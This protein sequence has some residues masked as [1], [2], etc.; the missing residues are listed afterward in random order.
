MPCGRCGAKTE[1]NARFCSGCGAPLTGGHP[2]EE[3]KRVS[4]IFVDQVGSTARA[5][6]ADP[7][8]V[9]DRNRLFYEEVR[10]RIEDH[11]GLLEKYAGDAVMAVF[12]A[13]L[14]R[15]ND[16]ESAVRAG[17]SVLEG[18][19]E[20]N[21][22]HQN[23]QLEVRIGICTGEAIVEIDPPPE[24]ALATG[25][26]VNTAARLESAAP[27]GAVIVGPETYRLTKH[28]FGYR[29]L[30]PIEA[31]GKKEP[32]PAWIVEAEA[33][34][35]PA[36]DELSASFVGRDRELLLLRTVWSQALEECQ[37]HLIT[38]IGP[39]GIGKSRLA[40][41]F[42][43]EA[44]RASGRILL[45]RCSAYEQQ[46]PYHAVAQTVRQAS[47]VFENDP[48]ETARAKVAT[49]VATMFPPDEAA[50]MTRFLSLV[51]GLGLDERAR[52][53]VELQ[54]AVRRFFERLSD[55]FP[56]LIVFEDL[57]WADDAS[58]ELVK[59]LGTRMQRGRTVVMTLARPELLESRPDW[60]AGATAHTSLALNPLR[61]DDSQRAA[62]ELLSGA[63]N[64]TVARVV[65]IAD[66]NP[67]FLEELAASI[68][69]D[70]DAVADD[71]PP[72]IHAVLAARVD[73]LPAD[74]RTA[75]LRA[76]VIGK[77]FWRGVL[78]TV[79][80][81]TDIDAALDAL[82]SRGLIHQRSPSQVEG[83]VEFEFK[84]DLVLD[85]AYSTLP[86]AS[87]RNLHAATASRLE[88]LA[89]EPEEFAGILAHHW[90]EAG[91][92]D[93]SRHYLLKAADRARQ[94][95][96]VEETYD[97]YSQA[98]ELAQEQPD[99]LAI[100]ALRAQAMYQLNDCARAVA[101]FSELI[102]LLEGEAQ[103]EALLGHANASLWTEQTDQTMASAERALALARAGAFADLEAIALGLVGAA[104]GMRGEAGDLQQAVTLMNEAL[105]N[106]APETRKAELAELWHL[107]A[108]HFY[109][110]GDYQRALEAS[111][112]SFTIARV[113]P[114]SQEYRLR[115]AGMQGLILA[116]MGH[117]EEAIAAAEG[118]IE[119]GHEMGRPVNVV[120]N[121]STL[122]LREIFALDD[123]LERSEA[124]VERLGPSDFNMPW[125]NAR[126][127]AF[128]AH[129]M[130][131]DVVVAE[132]TW[133]ALWDDAVASK[134]WERWLVSGRLAA[135]RAD[136]EL[137]LGRPDEAQKWAVRAMEMARASSR[138]K[139]EAIAQVTLGRALVASGLGE[140]AAGQLR[141][142]LAAADVIG[143]PFIKWQAQAALGAALAAAGA[144][145]S[146]P[147]SAAA[148]TVRSIAQ[149]LSPPRAT[150]FLADPRITDVLGAASR[151]T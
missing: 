75:L 108:D 30:P 20:L 86:R 88:V 22:A 26:V 72:T 11:G 18:V 133:K 89:R 145:S 16:A 149:D 6:G 37:P 57:H 63:D 44:V 142:A 99:R 42:R 102:P 14:T 107:S 137:T 3:R 17:L 83:D 98:L 136:L 140:E 56:L 87:R 25:D 128:V 101:E 71:L 23:L 94:A 10:G 35:R 27:P 97:L 36:S 84:H 74:A 138:K 109:W 21:A 49:L 139:Y 53:T 5:D 67:L 115:G 47:G 34:P 95:F 61:A 96:A 29:A 33:V 116:G 41:E 59:Y 144:D 148:G 73:A 8:D 125:M 54:Y 65:A 58:L 117:Y 80:G 76:S 121:Y 64:A 113:E 9:R 119:L 105:S 114:Y 13:P 135:A 40:G 150:A 28:V 39:A 78:E 68:Q 106:W 69:D 122:P 123:A 124:V 62:R 134:A 90:R 15:S 85:T 52:E 79:G 7:E 91:D 24:S 143:S 60:G 141:R 38:L 32:V 111:A 127:D 130:K 104:H 118:A 103:I 45:G 81:V 43:S 131:G 82:E 120:L 151:G 132:R 12:G 147:Y 129:V 70:A 77:V 146:A 19:S 51:M 100:R 48:A 2:H 55:E 92:S 66:G 110:Y 4:I 31:K 93:R 1:P 126:A 112:T 50:D 46:T